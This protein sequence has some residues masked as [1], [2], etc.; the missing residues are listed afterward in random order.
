MFFFL[1]LVTAG[2]ALF[3]F[4]K[5]LPSGLTA[6]KTDPLQPVGTMMAETHK[7][8]GPDFTIVYGQKEK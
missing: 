5:S 3:L 1:N 7:Q 6:A 4:L 8:L 2:E